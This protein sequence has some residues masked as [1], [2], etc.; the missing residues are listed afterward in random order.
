MHDDLELRRPRRLERLDRS[1]VRLIDRLDKGARQEAEAFEEQRQKAGEFR[2]L[3][4]EEQDEAPCDGRDVAQHR[5]K[6]ADDHLNRAANARYA[7]GDDGQDERDDGGK[8]TRGDGVQDGHSERGGNLPHLVERLGVRHEL[9]D[10][11]HE[12]AWEILGRI[13]EAEVDVAARDKGHREEGD[14]D[15]CIGCV[16]F[17]E[18]QRVGRRLPLACERFASRL[19]TGA[20]ALL[21]KSHQQHSAVELEGSSSP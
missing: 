8:R 9:V 15:A 4:G 16:S 12:T 10:E 6:R 2:L 13:K 19:A 18:E 1:R 14:E 11:P 17:R 3:E 7:R 20:S 5:R 21:E